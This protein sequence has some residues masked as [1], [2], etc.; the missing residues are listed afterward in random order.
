M[1]SEV[2]VGKRRCSYAFTEMLA[3]ASGSSGD[4]EE[5]DSGQV[6]KAVMPQLGHGLNGLDGG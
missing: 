5:M 6:L 3:G 2:G 4:E 1:L